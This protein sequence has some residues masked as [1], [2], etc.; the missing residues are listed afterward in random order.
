M[1]N[2]IMY[3]FLISLNLCYAPSHSQTVLDGVFALIG[4]HVIFHSDIEKQMIQYQ[5]QGVIENVDTLRNKLIEELFFQKMLLHFASEDSL[6][7]DYSQIQNTINQRI[8]FFTEQ[9]GSV[10]KVENYFQ[11]SI[12]ELT[13]ELEPIV[14]DQLMVQQMQYQITQDVDVSPMQL[15]DYILSCNLDSLPIVESQFQVGHILKIPN[16]ADLAIDETMSKLESLRK[17]IIQGED[18]ATMAILYS[19]DPGS[20]RNGGAYYDIKKGDFVKEF[21]AV[22]FSLNVDEVSDIFSTEYGYH[23]AKLID[24]KGNKIDVR[25]ILMTPKIST[26]DMLNVKF[27]LDSIKQDINANVISFSAAA[28]DFS[29]DEETRYNS[30]LLINPNTNSSFFVTQELNPTILNQIETMSVGDITDPI[31]IKMPNGKEAYRIIKLV[32]KVD[33]HVANLEDDYAFL[34]SYYLTIKKEKT[35]RLWY[36]EKVSD[37]FIEPSEALMNSDFYQKLLN[38]E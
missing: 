17:R 33:Q 24:R 5:S 20:S 16:A 19:E 8:A 3:I 34:Q 29:S 21:E 6:E 2:R 11:K 10:E 37:L 36:N 1:N 30:G 38:N 13:N 32:S 26:Q 31:Y 7:V 35:I 27:F 23:I 14:K 22:S 15:K 25:H 9:L 12:N 4:D 18:F 28:K